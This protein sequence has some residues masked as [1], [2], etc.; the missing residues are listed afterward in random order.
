MRLFAYVAQERC[1]LLGE[2]F[3][4]WYFVVPIHANESYSVI[5]SPVEFVGWLHYPFV[6]WGRSN[7]CIIDLLY[8]VEWQRHL[9]FWC[10]SL[11]SIDAAE[12]CTYFSWNGTVSPSSWS[13][14][15]LRSWVTCASFCRFLLSRLRKRCSLSLSL[16]RRPRLGCADVN[17]LHL[18]APPDGHDSWIHSIRPW[19]GQ[20]L[21]WC[22]SRT[23][24]ALPCIMVS[25]WILPWRSSLSSWLPTFAWWWRLFAK[26]NREESRK[27]VVQSVA[28]SLAET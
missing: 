24:F 17:S 18:I 15:S 23:V 10:R 6:V 7:Q 27:R 19:C 5:T 2:R 4:C 14:W 11:W 3:A 22:Q 20:H 8:L 12:I 21:S 9:D 1:L 28:T 13:S 16:T 26:Q 25:V